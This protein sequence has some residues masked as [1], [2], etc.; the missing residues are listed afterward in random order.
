MRHIGYGGAFGTKIGGGGVPDLMHF[1]WGGSRGR[2]RPNVQFARLTPLARHE[3]NAPRNNSS[4]HT[5]RGLSLHHREGLYHC[6]VQRPGEAGPR[7][8]IQQYG[9]SQP[10]PATATDTS[11]PPVQQ[12]PLNPVESQIPFPLPGQRVPPPLPNFFDPNKLPG[13]TAWCTRY[14]RR[15]AVWLH[16]YASAYTAYNTRTATTAAT[17]FNCNTIRWERATATAKAS[18][19]WSR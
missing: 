11:P 12:R 14:T 7:D 8:P 19:G 16:T 3:R 4:R 5:R 15:C 9:G 13:G 10:Q 17:A 2:M 1:D 6:H 18:R